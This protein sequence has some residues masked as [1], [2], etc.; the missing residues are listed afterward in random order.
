MKGWTRLRRN[1]GFAKISDV[2]KRAE[3]GKTYEVVLMVQDGRVRAYIDGEKVHD[4]T[5]SDP[6]SGGKFGLRTWS[7]NI[8]VHSVEVGRPE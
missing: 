4:W 5:D 6:L 1:P 2:E 7:S 8:T 3:W